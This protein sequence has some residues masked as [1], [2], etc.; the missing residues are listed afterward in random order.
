M[1]SCETGMLVFISYS[2]A[3][4]PFV[5]ML[6]RAL[7]QHSI[8]V[9]LDEH[10]LS[11]GESLPHRL[12]DAISRADYIIIVIS[13]NSM[14]SAWVY[15]ELRMVLQR[16]QV[17]NR[18]CLLPLLLHGG[19]LPAELADRIIADFRAAQSMTKAFPHL[20]R[21]L[22]VPVPAPTFEVRNNFYHGFFLAN[23]ATSM[24][25]MDYFGASE[26]WVSTDGDLTPY[27]MEGQ[28]VKPMTLLGRIG[29]TLGGLESEVFAEQEGVI[30]KILVKNLQEVDNGQTLFILRQPNQ[31]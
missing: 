5:R 31:P 25:G 22:G 17:E 21:T 3:D 10:E 16:E 29:I 27:V 12:A 7:K 15:Y 6:Y 4:A 18:V 30:E 9:W 20:L 28:L 11:V 14:G 26:P 1:W 8:S 13:P 24:A 2:H 23:P 19:H